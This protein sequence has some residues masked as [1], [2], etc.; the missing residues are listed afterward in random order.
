M[1]VKEPLP[2]NGVRRIVAVCPEGLL[3]LRDRVL[4]TE[5]LWFIE[6]SRWPDDYAARRH[7]QNCRSV[8]LR[9]P[10]SAPH[11]FEKDPRDSELEN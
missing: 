7:L 4:V 6:G 10:V 2:L 5:Q 11:Q 8:V 1:P 9:V 3:G